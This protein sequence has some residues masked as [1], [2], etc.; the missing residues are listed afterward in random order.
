[1]RNH[2]L[3]PIACVGILLLMACCKPTPHPPE[4]MKPPVNE[5][6]AG[7]YAILENEYSEKW[8]E[9]F[10]TLRKTIQKE[11]TS[12]EHA[13]SPPAAYYNDTALAAN[14]RFKL[15]VK[16]GKE[17]YAISAAEGKKSPEII[18][19][20]NDPLFIV[21][22]HT[23]ASNSFIFIESISAN[24]SEVRYLPFSSS[25][26]SPL[27]MQTR[28][29]GVSYSAEHFGGNNIWILSNENAPMRSVLIAP[30]SDPVSVYWKTAVRENDSVY[31][32]DYTVINQQ[33]LI[34]VQRKN[35]NASIEISDIYADKKSGIENKINFP[36]PEGRVRDLTYDKDEDKLVFTYSS[37]ITPPTCY[38]YGLHS[39]HLG[40]RWQKPVR[41]YVQDDYKAET[42]RVSNKGRHNILVS[43]IRKQN[44]EKQNVA[45]PLLLFIESSNL[46]K[47]ASNFDA[48]LISLLSR[49]CSVA[50]VHIPDDFTSDAGC[51]DAITA[52][53]AA[54][55]GKNYV[56]PGMISLYAKGEGSFW[57]YNAAI[58]HPSWFNALIFDSPSF[59]NLA[60]GSE[61]PDIYF[62]TNQENPAK[63]F[64]S[65][66]LA[67]EL[68]NM[69]KPENT[70]LVLT[71]MNQEPARRANL[72]TFILACY[73]IE[74]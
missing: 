68:R 37:S 58:K 42:I 14:G 38:A 70:L 64:E 48:G 20:E 54:L 7:S 62:I 56:T 61:I 33:Y 1:M 40:I 49:G 67:S 30:A 19:T 50:C 65:I 32:D 8:L 34:L 74:K 23:S 31:I 27:L 73:G 43:L 63:Y 22:L 55:I 46:R 16:D 17:V 15:Y 66:T 28:K 45:A 59:S 18:F 60:G 47:Q 3:F 10:S 35:L 25:L 9:Q 29:P 41:N 72:I 2:Q 71:G 51:T 11:L 4:A 21:R 44:L 12:R 6:S 39:M 36:E 13:V 57:A 53:V 52:A 26:L 5:S 24:S 69:T